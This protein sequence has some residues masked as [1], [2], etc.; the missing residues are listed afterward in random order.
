MG[1]GRKEGGWRPLSLADPAWDLSLIFSSGPDASAPAVSAYPSSYCSQMKALS[2]LLWNLS[3]AAPVERP[4]FPM[5]EDGFPEN[6]E[7]SP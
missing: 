5:T 7:G 2:V 6:M 3:V 4:Q 1:G